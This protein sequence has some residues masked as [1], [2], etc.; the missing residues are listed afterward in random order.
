MTLLLAITCGVMF[1]V[2][3]YFLM[4][5]TLLQMVLGLIAIGHGANLAIFT[6]AGLVRGAA[7]LVR[8]GETMPPPG[9]ADALPQA[10]ILTAIVIGFAVTAFAA[11]LAM[12]T[13]QA[14]GSDDPDDMTLTDTQQEDHA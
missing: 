1:A 8:K 13:F 7:P 9:V 2:G 3:L 10:L 5:R 14:V 4:Q 11:V 6:S 12:R